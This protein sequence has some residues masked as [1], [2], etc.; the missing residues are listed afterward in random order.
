[1]PHQLATGTPWNSSKERQVSSK[2]QD[3]LSLT[4]AII[5]RRAMITCGERVGQ[6]VGN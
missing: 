2:G 5:E 4:K 1:M 6:L 3:T